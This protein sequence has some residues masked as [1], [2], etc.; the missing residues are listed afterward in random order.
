MKNAG[1]FGW[2]INILEY[3][4]TR[5][6]TYEWKIK[7][8]AWAKLE[9]QTAGGIFSRHG[10]TARAVKLTIQG[11]HDVTLHNAVAYA[12]T[13]PGHLVL[14]DINREDPGYTVLSAAAIEPVRC[15]VER[16]RVETGDNNRPKTR[17][18]EPLVF[19]G[20]LTEKYL[21]Q[22]QQE[23]MSYSETRLVLITPKVITIMVGQ[24]VTIGKTQYETVIPHMLDP[25]R[26]EFEILGRHDN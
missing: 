6:N 4:K 3:V 10:I 13:E 7:S 5:R 18:L 19:Q 26:N 11:C 23:P 15:R 9:K 17:K 2:R 16:V 1:D 8:R 21:R 25:Y 14:T 22:N 20:Y 24:L 12:D